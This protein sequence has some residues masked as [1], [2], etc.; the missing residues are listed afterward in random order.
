MAFKNEYI[1]PL[2]QET[3]AFLKKARETLRTGYSKYDMWKVD[4]ERDMVLFR[5]GGGHSMEAKDEE[6]FSFIAV[7]GE[8]C[9]DTDRLAQSKVRP[10]IVAVTRRIRFRGDPSNAP[11]AA[12]LMCIKDALQENSRR[13]L[14]KLEHYQRCQLTLIDVRTGEE[15]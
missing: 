7:H 15:I 11:D 8:Y 12:T 3:S 6:Y 10:G 1:P 14:F 13:Y 2:E 9:C 4:R 5:R